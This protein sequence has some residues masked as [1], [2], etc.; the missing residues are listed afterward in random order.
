MIRRNWTTTRSRANPYAAS[1]A[2]QGRETRHRVRRRKLNPAGLDAMGCVV[3]T[4][5]E[6]RGDDVTRN[7][8]SDA[9][10][11]KARKPLASAGD[12]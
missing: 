10:A 2:C 9:A 4:S 6:H 11:A 5:T 7:A 8:A 1:A 12:R 3:I